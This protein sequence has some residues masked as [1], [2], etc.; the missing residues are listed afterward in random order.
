MYTV[1]QRREKPLGHLLKQEVL[2][3]NIVER[4][5]EGYKGKDPPRK[6]FMS[7]MIELTGCDNNSDI[8]RLTVARKEWKK[9]VTTTRRSLQKINLINPKFKYI[10]LI[11]IIKIKYKI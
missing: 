2:L 10:N 7:E 3:T 8:K 11:I 4:R 1:R 9:L 5:I 6:T